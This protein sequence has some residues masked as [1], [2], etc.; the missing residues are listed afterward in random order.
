MKTLMNDAF[1]AL[2]AIPELQWVDDNLGQFNEETTTVE[3]P[4][5]L[6]GIGNIDQTAY[7]G[8]GQ[9][10]D[11]TLEITVAFAKPTTT[12]NFPSK[13]HPLA[14]DIYDLIR[15]IDK[16]IL[17][18]EGEDYGPLTRT[19]ITTDTRYFPV[20]YILSYSTVLYE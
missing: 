19:K 6:V 8:S 15:K 5:A 3:Y 14:A 2:S 4:C 11:I 12:N 1:M 17:L 18:L 13:V 20:R 16:A 10:G 7:N 9:Y